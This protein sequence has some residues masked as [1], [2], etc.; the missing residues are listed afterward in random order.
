MFVVLEDVVIMICIL[1]DVAG[2]S[3]GNSVERLRRD[4]NAI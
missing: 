3:K 4:V 2:I 1:Y